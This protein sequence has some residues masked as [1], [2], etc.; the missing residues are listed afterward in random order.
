MMI[1]ALLFLLV[2][3]SAP[4]SGLLEKMQEELASLGI[5]KISVNMQGSDAIVLT[6]GKGYHLQSEIVEVWS[7]GQTRWIYNPDSGEIT[8]SDT[9]AAS[10]DI[11][12]NPV[13]LLT[14]GILNSYDVVSEKG[15]QILLRAKNN[16]KL[17]YPQIG[18][19]VD[20]RGLPDKLTL[21]SASGEIYVI[22]I[23]SISSVPSD[24][25]DSFEPSETFLKNSFVNDMR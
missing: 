24:S 21:K 11:F 13:V 19:S 3:V 20:G 15:S 2:M 22:Q 10:V 6:D 9:D 8:V 12:E 5:V 7:N 23:I 16:L 25:D 1:S 18:I 17:S 14:S 4:S